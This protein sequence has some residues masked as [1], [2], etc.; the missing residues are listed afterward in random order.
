MSD[1][2]SYEVQWVE[3]L[4]AERDRSAS[5]IAE[6]RAL[7]GKLDY[8][9][10]DADELRDLN[11]HV[12]V[13][14]AAAEAELLRRGLVIENLW[15]RADEPVAERIEAEFAEYRKLRAISQEGAIVLHFNGVSTSCLDPERCERTH[16]VVWRRS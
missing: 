14:L 5:Q 2:E 16:Y 12:G 11:E 13:L 1:D 8:A 6:I 15:A 9:R 7:Q 3:A 4:Q 10:A